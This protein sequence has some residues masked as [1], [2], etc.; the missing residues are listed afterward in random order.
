MK[1][2]LMRQ[3]KNK[4][5]VSQFA[6][7]CRRIRTVGR[8]ILPASVTNTHQQV[9]MFPPIFTGNTRIRWLATLSN[10]RDDMEVILAVEEWFLTGEEFLS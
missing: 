1:L 8:V 3:E 6:E 10:Q 7:Q 2:G 5:S 4:F 9:F